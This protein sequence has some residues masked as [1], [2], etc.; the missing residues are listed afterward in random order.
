[1]L[2]SQNAK[3]TENVIKMKKEYFEAKMEFQKQMVKDFDNV[4]KSFT[5]DLPQTS[6]NYILSPQIKKPD[7]DKIGKMIND[8]DLVLNKLPLNT[9]MRK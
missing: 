7:F 4:E 1:M 8:A 3:M 9:N 2:K 6:K 5:F